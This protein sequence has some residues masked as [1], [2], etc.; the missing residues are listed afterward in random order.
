[1]CEDV[2]E[3]E[4]KSHSCGA[5]DTCINTRGSFKCLKMECPDGYSLITERDNKK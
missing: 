4:Q 1:M 2:D 3:C 5:R